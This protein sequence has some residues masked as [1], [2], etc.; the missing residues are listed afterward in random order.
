METL[1][2]KVIKTEEQYW[3]YCNLLEKLVDKET[4]DQQEDEIELLTFLI[5]KWDEDHQL[6]Q[7]SDPVTLLKYLMEENNM[8]PKDLAALLAVSKSVVSEILNY[9]KGFSKEII[10]KLAERFK[11]KQE[12]FNRIYPLISS[13]KTKSLKEL[14][15]EN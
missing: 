14:S 1:K 5:E 12:A 15:A 11:V 10:R 8:K 3:Q 9:K 4:N 6:S 7:Q 2:Y 13:D